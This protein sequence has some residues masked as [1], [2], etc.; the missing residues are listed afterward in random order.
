MFEESIGQYFVNAIKRV[1][2]EFIEPKFLKQNINLDLKKHIIDKGINENT[3]KLVIDHVFQSLESTLNVINNPDL[4][5][6]NSIHWYFI[7]KWNCI[8]A[9]KIKHQEPTKLDDNH[10]KAQNEFWT[11]YEGKNPDGTYNED[12]F[13]LDLIKLNLPKD[14]FTAERWNK[15][16]PQDLAKTIIQLDEIPF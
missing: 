13:E 7:K 5:N 6:P 1:H 15:K 10:I 11:Q 12:C 9:I 3:L 14:F 2:P 8:S 4:K 16:K